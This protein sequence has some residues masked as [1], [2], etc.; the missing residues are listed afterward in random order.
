MKRTPKSKENLT[1]IL[2]S[3]HDSLFSHHYEHESCDIWPYNGSHKIHDDI[4][5]EDQK[6]QE[7]LWKRV[8]EY[9][10]SDKLTPNEKNFKEH[11]V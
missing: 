7:L 11:L 5:E 1:P 3:S 9:L 4:L 8:H 6:E 2:R 10:A